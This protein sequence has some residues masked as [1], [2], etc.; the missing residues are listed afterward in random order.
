VIDRTGLSD[1]SLLAAGCNNCHTLLPKQCK[2][3]SE[4]K[5]GSIVNQPSVISVIL[6]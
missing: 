1:R 3:N 4:Q 5:S 2:R 6:N